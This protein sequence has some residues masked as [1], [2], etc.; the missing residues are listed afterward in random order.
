M[1]KIH[2]TVAAVVEKHG[3]FLV[4]EEFVGGREVINQPAGHVE[5]GEVLRDAVMREMLEETAWQFSPAAIVGIYLWTHPQKDEAFLRVAFSGTCHDFDSERELDTG[6]LRTLWLTQHELEA[7]G[8]SLRSPMVLRAIADY[9]E[10][11]RYPVNMFQQLD[12]E[13]LAV[14]AAVV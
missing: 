4:V 8:D 10:G 5:S 9:R 2:L 3:R 7:R 6:I 12:L 13:D 14:R 1:Q 11:G